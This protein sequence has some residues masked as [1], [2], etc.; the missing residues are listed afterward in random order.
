MA[1]SEVGY[2]EAPET[3]NVIIEFENERNKFE[4]DKETGRLRSIA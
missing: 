1:Y 2:D 4:F 3:V